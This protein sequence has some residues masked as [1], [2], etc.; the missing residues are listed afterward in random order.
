MARREAALRAMR[1]HDVPQHRA[2]SHVGIEPKTVRR[3]R[4]QDNPEIRKEMGEIAEKRRRIGILLARKGISMNHKKFYWRYREEG[5]SVRRR[6]GRER[7][8]GSLSPMS[9]S[10]ASAG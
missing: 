1:D 7:A 5:P 9:C 2:F 10:P 8:C 4:P 6:W 3:E